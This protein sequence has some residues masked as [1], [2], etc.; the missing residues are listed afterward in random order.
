M[1]TGGG[2]GG[3]VESVTGNLVNNTD[4]ANPVIKPLSNPTATTAPTVNDDG[5]DG[6]TVG[7]TWFDTITGTLYI[8]KDPTNGAA[9][10]VAQG[11]PYLSYV[12]LL[13]QTGT[14]APTATV[15]MNNTGQTFTYTYDAS[16]QY[17]LNGTFDLSKTFVVF[18]NNGTGGLQI[19]NAQVTTTL[20][21]LYVFT[22]SGG[23]ISSDDVLV[24]TPIEIRIYP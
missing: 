21:G 20:I 14:D 11:N 6:Y 10:W 24:N 13:S 4:P 23:W 2:G 3:G 5:S 15:M 18:G 9:V 16:G 17:S 7:S 22:E 19:F 1:N 12:A 8:L